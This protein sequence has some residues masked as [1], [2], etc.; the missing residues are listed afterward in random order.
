[1]S[2]EPSGANHR[3]GQ[4]RLAS[5]TNSDAPPSMRAGQSRALGV[6]AA[7][8]LVLAGLSLAA[9]A[10]TGFTTRN[11]TVAGPGILVAAAGIA[12]FRARWFHL[13]GLVPS[14][15]ILG[16]AGPIL[17]YDLA[18]PGET[19]YFVGTVLIIVGGCLAAVF[20]TASAVTSARRALPVAVIIAA[21]ALPLA[22]WS[23]LSSSPASAATDVD[24][25]D[26]ERRSAVDVEMIDHFFVV[27][28]ALIR[29]GQVVHIRNTGALPHD[30]TVEGLDVAVFVPPGRGTYLRMPEADQETLQLICTVGDHLELGMRL[31]ID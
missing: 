8:S 3:P 31:D 23:V 14:V 27:D 29:G 30:F 2:V 24:I 25:S 17:A 5:V 18:R 21:A 20:G 4:E 7:A 16:I 15:A 11:W 22:F 26:T 1:M 6:I 28:P 19:P 9:Y 13:A 10:L 12:G